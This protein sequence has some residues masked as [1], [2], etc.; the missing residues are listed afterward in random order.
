MWIVETGTLYL[1]T[2]HFVVKST[3]KFRLKSRAKAFFDTYTA[4]LKGGTGYWHHM[5]VP[6]VRMREI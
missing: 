2:E 6:S 1:G 3:R 5:P 4:G